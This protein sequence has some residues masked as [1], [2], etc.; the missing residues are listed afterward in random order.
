MKKLPAILL[1]ALTAVCLAPQAG[2]ATIGL[3]GGLNFTSMTIKTT[4]TDM[5][6]FKNNTGLTGGIFVNFK[7]GPVSI[8]P[9]VLYS[10]RGLS[11][12]QET[13]EEIK[14]TSLML[15]DYVEV[16]VLVKYS[17]LSGPAKPFLYAGPS[18]SYLLKGRSGYDIDYLTSD[19]PDMNYYYDTTDSYKKTELAGVFG[20]GVDIKL[21]KVILSLEGRYHLGLSNIYD[22]PENP[23]V[24]SLKNKGF[25][26]LV[27]I[28]F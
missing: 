24:S 7:L 13:N 25:S 21:P 28:G 8:Q 1:I 12:D 19:E 23:E 10:R 3:K 27:G 9:E 17:F 15:V 4:Y 16:P 18:F 20:A 11:Y 22:E 5:P 6:E 2:A 14:V 26:V